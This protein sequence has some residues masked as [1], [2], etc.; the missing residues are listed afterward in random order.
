MSLGPMA[1]PT[2]SD[3]KVQ[4]QERRRA[5]LAA[6]LRSNL[7]K[8]KEQARGRAQRDGAAGAGEEST[9]ETGEHRADRRGSL[10]EGRLTRTP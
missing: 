1:Q 9:P 2:K 5:R 4:A 3:Q 7:Q 8:R 6:E 10:P